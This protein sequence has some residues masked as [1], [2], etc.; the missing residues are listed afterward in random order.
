KIIEE[1]FPNLNKEMP[2]N[3]QK[4]YRTPNRLDQKT[5]SS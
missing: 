5:N 4:A 1:N 3:I 2:M